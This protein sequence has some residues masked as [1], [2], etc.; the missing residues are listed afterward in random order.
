MHLMIFRARVIQQYFNIFSVYD[1]DHSAKLVTF[2]V[3]YFYRQLRQILNR[4]STE[5]FG[6]MRESLISF[7]VNA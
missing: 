3:E 6:I 5:S 7:Y 1:A 2:I 4:H